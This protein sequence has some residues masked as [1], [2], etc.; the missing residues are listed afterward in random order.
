MQYIKKNIEINTTGHTNECWVVDFKTINLTKL[1]EISVVMN[2]T[3]SYADL[4]AGKHTSD[5]RLVTVTSTDLELNG[6]IGYANI[7][8]LYEVLTTK[9][10]EETYYTEEPDENGVLVPVEKTRIIPVFPDFFGGE[11]ITIE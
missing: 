10:S 3:K 2:G 7:P 5:S 4:V 6:S 1:P 9:Q 8:K 11:I